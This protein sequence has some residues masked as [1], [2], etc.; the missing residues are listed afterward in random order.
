[1]AEITIKELFSQF[2][3]DYVSTTF[4]FFPATKNGV[5][6]FYTAA[7]VEEVIEFKDEFLKLVI[8]QQGKIVC[9]NGTPTLVN[10]PFVVNQLVIDKNLT[11]IISIKHGETV[12]KRNKKLNRLRAELIKKYGVKVEVELDE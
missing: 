10:S 2:K 7:S 11:F 8:E 4:K 12:T 9:T 3:V 1:M 5:L 6:Y